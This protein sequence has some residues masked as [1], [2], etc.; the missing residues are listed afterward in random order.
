MQGPVQ[1]AGAGGIC[2]RR[3]T[4][5]YDMRYITLNKNKKSETYIKMYIYLM[6]N[7]L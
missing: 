3:K 2:I 1:V 5:L 7:Y 4:I 6:Q